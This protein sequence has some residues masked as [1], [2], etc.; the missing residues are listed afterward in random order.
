MKFI[1]ALENTTN[2]SCLL[3]RLYLQFS[4]SD[5]I[6]WDNCYKGEFFFFFLRTKEKFYYVVYGGLMFGN[7][8][9]FENDRIYIITFNIEVNVWSFRCLSLGLGCRLYTVFVVS[10]LLWLSHFSCAA[11]LLIICCLKKIQRFM[12]SIVDFTQKKR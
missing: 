11:Q 10:F 7:S 3:Q 2:P 9:N 8:S 4:S 5:R 6:Y 12:L 1:D